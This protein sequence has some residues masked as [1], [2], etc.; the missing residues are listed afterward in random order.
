MPAK[1]RP[2]AWPGERAKNPCCEPKRRH[3]GSGLKTEHQITGSAFN[4][5]SLLHG[6]RARG[7]AWEGAQVEN[8][9]LPE[10]TPG[11]PTG[12][13]GQRLRQEGPSVF[14]HFRTPALVNIRHKIEQEHGLSSEFFGQKLKE[15]GVLHL[16]D[17]Q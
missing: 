6:K 16:Q 8:P 12:L 9:K 4:R 14:V 13:K 10:V 17:T 5:K 1:T 7:R 2:P 11:P 3:A 15:C